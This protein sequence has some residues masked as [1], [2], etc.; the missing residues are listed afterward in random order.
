MFRLLAT[1][2]RYCNT[3]HYIT[4]LFIYIYILPKF[5]LLLVNWYVLWTMYSVQWSHNVLYNGWLHDSRVSLCCELPLPSLCLLSVC[6]CAPLS[7]RATWHH[8]MATCSPRVMDQT[9]FRLCSAI[10]SRYITTTCER[11]ILIT[12]DP[13]VHMHILAIVA[14]IVIALSITWYE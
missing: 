12:N 4:Q 10:L 2:L 5:N 11:E 8:C 6:V 9:S 3:S 14:T 7:C 1:S 13:P